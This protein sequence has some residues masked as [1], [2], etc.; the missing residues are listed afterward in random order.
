[1][2]LKEFTKK[3]AIPVASAVIGGSAVFAAMKLDHPQVTTSNP[4][5]RIIQSFFDD[6]FFTANDPF[7]QMRKMHQQIGS[8]PSETITGISQRE[9]ES[10]V[11]YDIQLDDVNSTSVNTKVE[12]GYITITGNLEKRSG[13]NDDQDGYAAQ[14]IFKSSFNRTFPLPDNVDENKMETLTEKNKLILK[15]PKIKA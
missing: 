15:F 10:Y 11:Y 5:Q 2:N 14:S 1:M 4:H 7:E 8:F 6:D 9:D 12:N 3:S 13:S